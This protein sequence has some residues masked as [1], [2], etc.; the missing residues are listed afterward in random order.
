VSCVERTHVCLQTSCV[1]LQAQLAPLRMPNEFLGLGV[2]KPFSVPGVQ[3][4]AARLK[5]N[6]VYYS[7]NYALLYLLL[8]CMTII[9]SPTELITLAA[10][11]GGWILLLRA[12]PESDGVTMGAVTVKKQVAFVAMGVFS[13]LAGL[14]V[15]ARK[16][17]HAPMNSMRTSHAAASHAT[18]VDG[19]LSMICVCHS[20]SCMI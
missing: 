17:R 16:R 2:E 14:L 20:I 15:S 12:S 4:V 19:V 8:C 5:L 3:D 6:L 7:S 18:V 10:A 1:R 11:A 9:T 13:I